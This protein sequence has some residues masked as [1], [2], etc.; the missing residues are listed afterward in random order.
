[1]KEIDKIIKAIE[2]QSLND[3]TLWDIKDIGTYMK[4]SPSHIQQKVITINGF[5]RA[6][7]LPT[8]DNGG[9]RRWQPKEVKAWVNR[10]RESA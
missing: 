4:L 8:C 6:Y 9:Q 5:P 2:R 7:R 1:M 10:F 3:S